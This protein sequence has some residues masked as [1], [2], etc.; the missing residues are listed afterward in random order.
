MKSL[1]QIREELARGDYLLSRHAFRRIVERNISQTEVQEAGS[2][3]I[4]IE[5]YP[6]DKYSPSCLLLGFT[7]GNR[8]LHI[9]VSRDDTKSTRIVTIY[10][11]DLA[12]WESGFRRRRL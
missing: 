7:L 5:D 6:T 3:A 10:E 1:T 11:P 2:D 8:P 12:E 4:I 9:Q